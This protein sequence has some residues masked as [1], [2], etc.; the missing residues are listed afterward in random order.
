MRRSVQ[1]KPPDPAGP[2]GED[3]L[4]LVDKS[5]SEVVLPACAWPRIQK[6]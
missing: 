5:D 3:S 1:A 4:T 6:T 2:P